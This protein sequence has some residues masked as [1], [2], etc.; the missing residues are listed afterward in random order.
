MQHTLLR[1]LIYKST[2][3]VSPLEQTG[4]MLTEKI[5]CR[6]VKDGMLF[7]PNM[8]RAMPAEPLLTWDA[9]MPPLHDGQLPEAAETEAHYQ[10]N[11][12]GRCWKGQ[13]AAAVSPLRPALL[14]RL[15]SRLSMSTA[16]VPGMQHQRP[17]TIL[18]AAQIAA[19]RPCP[20]KKQ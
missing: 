6:A 12:P 18:R 4:I 13:E 14:R 3:S 2:N 1:V 10:S 15:S 8:A 11:L 9:V 7:I 5:E 19:E 17:K 16:P 20:R